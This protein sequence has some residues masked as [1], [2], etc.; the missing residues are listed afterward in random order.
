MDSQDSMKYW[1]NATLNYVQPIKNHKMITSK[2]KKNLREWKIK[3]ENQ[4]RRKLKTT[5]D[6][7]CLIDDFEQPHIPVYTKILNS[8]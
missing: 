3:L 7:E 1:M 8:S 5:I 4:N 6:Y 2:V